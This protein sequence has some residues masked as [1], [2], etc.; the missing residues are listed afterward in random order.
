MGLARPLSHL[1]KI[2]D[3]PR[4]SVRYDG[5]DTDRSV[6]ARHGISIGSVPLASPVP[7]R[8]AARELTP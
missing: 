5:H 4:L 6:R 1:R 2:G 3:S 7:G 8:V